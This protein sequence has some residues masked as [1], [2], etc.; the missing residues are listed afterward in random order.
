M[1]QPTAITNFYSSNKLNKADLLSKIADNDRNSLRH[2]SIFTY[3][4]SSSPAAAAAAAGAQE[5][6]NTAATIQ[7]ITLGITAATGV[8]G[9]IKSICDVFKSDKGTSTPAAAPAS[10]P[11]A[12]AT[13]SATELSKAVTDLVAKGGDIEAM[14]AKVATDKQAQIAE[15]ATISAMTEAELK[16]VATAEAGLET[17]N[18][19][20][21]GDGGLKSQ[22]AKATETEA[23]AEKEAN[24][25]SVLVDKN[26]G[27]FDK[28][29]KNVATAE[30][31]VADIKAALAKK[32][33]DPELTV[34]LGTAQ[35]NLAKA[36]TDKNTAEQALADAQKARGEKKQALNEAREVKTK[37]EEQVKLLLE[38][39][40]A[41]KTELSDA[42]KALK[43]KQAEQT[44]AQAANDKWA[45]AIANAEATLAT[46]SAKPTVA[47]DD[48]EKTAATNAATAATADDEQV[49]AAAKLIADQKAAEAKKKAEEE[50]KRQAALQDRK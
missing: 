40:K 1:T 30:K 2:S 15:A 47:V 26:Q 3:G 16:A 37:L 20:Y 22:L 14:R 29:V 31:S 27:I 33:G 36:L 7:N 19:Q 32:P 8:V 4:G 41:K 13:T 12:A 45:A 10:T 21:E 38:Q 39:I 6:A 49:A 5:A 48:S 24:A 18:T 25:A 42:K 43:D 50:A 23:T 28:A 34:K 46:Y 44:K 35:D 9:L 11:V 17:L